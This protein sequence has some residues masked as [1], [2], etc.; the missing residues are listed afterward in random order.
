MKRVSQYGSLLIFLIL[1]TW[2][3]R[4]LCC[5][6]ALPG[7]AEDYRIYTG[8][9]IGAFVMAVGI[10][11]LH[12]LC[13]TAERSFTL[14][15]LAAAALA[16][17]E[18]AHG[19][20]GPYLPVW[21][22]H[23]FRRNGTVLTSF[24]LLAGFLVLHW[25]RPL[26]RHYWVVGLVSLEAVGLC[27]LVSFLP[28]GSFSQDVNAIGLRLLETGALAEP[29]YW[30]ALWML[31]LGVGV[32]AAAAVKTV[33]A[34]RLLPMQERLLLERYESL[35]SGAQS[36]AAARRAW[37]HQVTVAESIYWQGDTKGL[38]ALLRE[39]DKLCFHDSRPHYSRNVV[40]NTVLQDAASRAKRNGIDFRA[41]ALVPEILPLP[42]AELCVLL[43]SMLDAALSAATEADGE[44]SLRFHARTDAQALHVLCENT[45]EGESPNEPAGSSAFSEEQERRLSLVRCVIQRHQGLLEITCAGDRLAIQAI[46]PYSLAPPE[47]STAD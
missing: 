18:A 23:V 41:Q 10:L 20:A 46:L 43:M 39:M 22:A 37:W 26:W 3:L 11:L 9:A 25:K 28:G 30:L 42:E 45:G 33:A 5:S 15:L 1:C 17:H 6:A 34:A 44:L 32:S 35:R 24:L 31:L 8:A 47:K 19:A 12:L 7:A 27:Y 21:F 40:L 29:A 4:L 16:G 38:G 14:L 13:G 2:A 36:A